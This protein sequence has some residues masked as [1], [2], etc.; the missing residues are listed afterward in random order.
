MVHKS[1]IFLVTL[2]C[3]SMQLWIV[4]AQ[5]NNYVE[6]INPKL[7]LYIDDDA[8]VEVIAEGFKWSEGPVWVDALD[9]LLFS[10]VP[11]NKVYRWSEANGLQLF[12][13][14]SGY[15][16]ITPSTKKG[17]SNGLTLD[18]MEIWCFVCTE[19]GELPS[20]A[21][22]TKKVF[23]QWWI[24]LMEN[25]LTVLTILYMPRTEICISQTLLMG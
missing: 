3:F 14:P 10:D 24:R 8:T 23:L 15:T 21:V 9:A 16:G 12:L 5:T 11:N 25:D 17:G 4:Q 2:V 20:L 6:R 22:G 18:S 7:D 19:I 13:S 1:K